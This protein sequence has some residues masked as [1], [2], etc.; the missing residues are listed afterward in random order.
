[1]SQSSPKEFAND[2]T[3]WTLLGYFLVWLDG[4]TSYK[5][6]LLPHS[7][8]ILEFPKEWSASLLL[9]WFY[10]CFQITVRVSDTFTANY[11]YKN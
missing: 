2:L 9:S 1:M 5:T 7:V 10:Y 11:D 4:Q 3:M 8:P 6:F